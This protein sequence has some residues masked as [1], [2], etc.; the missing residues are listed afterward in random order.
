M[1]CIEVF[2]L[3]CLGLLTWWT[4]DLSGPEMG[5]TP[6]LRQRPRSGLLL[7][8]RAIRR[9]PAWGDPARHRE[10]GLS[11][12]AAGR[13]ASDRSA[14]E[15]LDRSGSRGVWLG[16]PCACHTRP[17]WKP[18]PGGS[19]DQRPKAAADPLN[20]VTPP[21]GVSGPA[22]CR[23]D[24]LLEQIDQCAG[25]CD[26][27]RDRSSSGDGATG[28]HRS[29]SP[30]AR[31]ALHLDVAFVGLV[32]VVGVALALAAVACVIVVRISLLGHG[33]GPLSCRPSTRDRCAGGRE[34][35]LWPP[36]FPVSLLRSW[37]RGP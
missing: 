28:L 22:V 34:C 4:G 14:A 17:R 6:S 19:A 9:R 1:A 21:K 33:L 25:C 5:R 15:S 37:R 29:S 8:R 7:Y 36:T 24:S 3:L 10:G 12:P 32:R 23:S 18:T 35:D 30:P 20:T 13:R 31:P 27:L 26:R 2:W 16:E 11:R